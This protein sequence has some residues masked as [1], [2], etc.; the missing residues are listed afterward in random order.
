MHPADPVVRIPPHGYYQRVVH[1][2]ASRATLPFSAFS[3]AVL[4]AIV[5]TILEPMLRR[6]Q[7][8]AEVSGALVASNT[9]I[10]PCVQ[11]NVMGL[12]WHARETEPWG[13][14]AIIASDV[15]LHANT[16]THAHTPT[17]LD[18]FSVIWIK[19]YSRRTIKNNQC[20]TN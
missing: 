5:D 14:Q 10:I 2:H 20:S 17:P 19:G 9:P 16:C 7:M 18:Y 8:G 6:R 11:A 3:F 4:D 12:I 13:I 15:D 1:V